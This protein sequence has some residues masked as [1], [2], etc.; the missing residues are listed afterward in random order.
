LL[1]HNATVVGES[2]YDHLEGMRSAL[3]FGKSV[4]V[5][6]GPER[7]RVFS[8]MEL[9]R[10]GSLKT[11]QSF[12]ALHEA[13]MMSIAQTNRER[14]PPEPITDRDHDMVDVVWRLV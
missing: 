5:A 3:K 12:S 14:L 7:A 6:E 9:D 10:R 13:M 2:W 1:V 8:A 11:D 4:V